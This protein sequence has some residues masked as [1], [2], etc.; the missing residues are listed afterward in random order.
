MG[1]DTLTA[2]EFLRRLTQ[3]RIRDSARSTTDKLIVDQHRIFIDV[4]REYEGS[5]WPWVRWVAAQ[6]HE[7]IV[8]RCAASEKFI[9]GD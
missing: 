5:R 1:D 3:S 4:L 2:D 8:C 6:M 9:I 7:E